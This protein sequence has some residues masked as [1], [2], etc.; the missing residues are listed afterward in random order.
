MYAHG[1]VFFFFFFF[2]FF[3]LI[4]HFFPPFPLSFPPFSFVFSCV[5][6]ML[7]RLSRALLVLTGLHYEGT[8]VNRTFLVRK[9]D[10]H[11]TLRHVEYYMVVLFSALVSARVACLSPT[12]AEV[13]TAVFY[14]FYHILICVK[15]FKNWNHN[16]EVSSSIE[17]ILA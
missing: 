4:P 7:G 9:F 15:V 1:D 3:D 8:S 6:R 11:A 14:C 13:K 16:Y 17:K 5:F 12:S 2:F 10:H